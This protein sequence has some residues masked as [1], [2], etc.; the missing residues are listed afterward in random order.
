MKNEI[1]SLKDVDNFQWA[2]IGGG[3]AGIAA[4]GKLIDSGIDGKNIAWVDPAFTVGDFGEKWP[5]VS[6]NTKVSLF[7]KFLY[8]CTSFG[9]RE[10]AENHMIHALDPENTCLLQH[11]V[12]PLIWV[13]EHLKTQ[14]TSIIGHAEK[15]KMKNRHWQISLTDKKIAAQNVIL[16]IGAEPKTLALSH[17]AT[18]PLNHALNKDQL[19]NM[20]DKNDV[21]AVFGS[22]HSAIIVIRLLLELGVSKVI[23]FYRNTLRYA[24]YLDNWILF[25]NTG[26]KGETAIWARENLDGNQPANLIRIESNTTNIEDWLPQCSKMIHAVGFS[27]RHIQ[28]EGLSKITY[29]AKSGII[30]PGLFGCGIAFP[31]ETIDKFGNVELNVGLWKFMHYLDRVMPVWLLYGA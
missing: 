14:V 30:A 28:I 3:P 5:K 8:S 16:A 31:E 17:P 1:A 7:L 11:A 4:V 19:Q 29:N 24:V 20:V 15:L 12:E 10:C 18:I 21:V 27:A 2:V 6:S 22:S 25:D 23:N 9:Y 13:T 26:L